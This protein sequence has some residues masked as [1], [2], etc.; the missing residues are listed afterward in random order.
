M[1]PLP[2]PAPVEQ[3][4]DW[5]LLRTF[6]V[7]VEAGGIT[8]AA[9]ALGLRQPTVSTALKRL[10]TQLGRRLIER[11]NGVF[12]VTAAGEVLHREAVEI[13]GNISRVS[14]L[15][16]DVREEVAGH[17]TIAMA[18]HVVCP[19]FD[20]LLAAFHRDHPQVS[21]TVEVATSATVVQGVLQKS[22]SLGICLVHHKHPQ[23][24][25]T[26]M[27]REHFGFFCGPAHRLFGR[28]GLKL[29]DLREES[30]VS[31]KTDRLTDALRPIALLRARENIEDRIIGTSSHLEEVRRMI[32]AG[33]GVGPLPIHVVERDVHD[34][35]L[36]QLPPY[37][38]PPAIDIFLVT[39][40]R[41][42]LNRAERAFVDALR[43]RIAVMPE[44]ERVLPRVMARAGAV[45][46]SLR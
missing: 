5:N 7:I 11:G 10:E 4:L 41:A 35:L 14:V 30:F 3:R 45:P 31:F 32:V 9:E 46:R 21:W 6:M 22:A 15:L 8:R 43:A 20:E 17:V 16:R 33:L 2:D 40:P 44:R 24:E 1:W 38:N 19:F 34:G 27:Y 23:L 25:Y 29:R 26:H 18:S 12:R 36:W 42:Q 28:R 37:R 13:Y 39:N